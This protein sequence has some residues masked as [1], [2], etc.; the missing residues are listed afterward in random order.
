M[1]AKN[2]GN[3]VSPQVV[4]LPLAL[5]PFVYSFAATNMNVAT[6]AIAAD[7]GTTVHGVQFTITLFTSHH[8]GPGDPRQQAAGYLFG[9][10]SA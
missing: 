8:G 7:L 2:T 4:V 3:A 9:S 6:G 10:D 1:M 5:A